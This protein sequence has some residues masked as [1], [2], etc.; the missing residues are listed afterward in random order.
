MPTTIL[1]GESHDD[2][3]HRRFRE[4]AEIDARTEESIAKDAE[5]YRQLKNHCLGPRPMYCVT[6]NTGHDWSRV[7][8]IDE[9]D[10]VLDADIANVKS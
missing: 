1:D 9:L 10:S 8:E 2:A 4:E 6:I 3:R 7:S 5:R